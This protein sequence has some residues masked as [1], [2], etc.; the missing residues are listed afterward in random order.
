MTSV[1]TLRL[2]NT[3]SKTCTMYTAGT[4]SAT[5]STRLASAARATKGLSCRANSQLIDSLPGCRVL[6][7]AQTRRRLY[8]RCVVL[9]TVCYRFLSAGDNAAACLRGQA[10]G[11]PPYVRAG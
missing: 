7:G 10:A 8:R 6:L 3:R 1:S 5:L 2:A 4:R 11:S 9:E